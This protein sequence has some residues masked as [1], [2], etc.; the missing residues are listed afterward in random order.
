MADHAFET[1]VRVGRTAQA[2][3]DGW[4]RLK[5]MVQKFFFFFFL[6]ALSIPREPNLE[7]LMSGLGVQ[8]VPEGKD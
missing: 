5:L 8:P 7:V 6:M 1:S 2:R 3:K 4:Y